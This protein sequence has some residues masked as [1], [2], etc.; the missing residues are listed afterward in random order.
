MNTVFNISW[1]MI[2]YDIEAYF[3]NVKPGHVQTNIKLYDL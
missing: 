3:N 1:D 2:D